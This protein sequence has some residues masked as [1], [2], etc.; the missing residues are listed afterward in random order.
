MFL[1]PLYTNHDVHRPENKR[2]S[3]DSSFSCSELVMGGKTLQCEKPTV[4]YRQLREIS[5]LQRIIMFLGSVKCNCTFTNVFY[6]YYYIPTTCF[7]LYGPSSGGIYI[8]WLLPN[9]L[10]FYNGSVFLVLVINCVS[11]YI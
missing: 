1:R 8:Y 5:I 6:Y 4:S 9:Q 3:E 11:V 7:G 2:F 10:F